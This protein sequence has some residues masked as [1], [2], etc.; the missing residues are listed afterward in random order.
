[1]N[2]PSTPSIIPFSVSRLAAFLSLLCVAGAESCNNSSATQ[3]PEALVASV[4]IPVAASTS[5]SYP[6]LEKYEI[7]NAILNRIA[8]PAGFERIELQAG[9]FG[10][11]LRYLPL[12]PGKP[13]IHLY[14][15]DLKRNQNVHV[16]VVDID[17]GT[18]DIQQC[19]D[20]VMRIRAEYLY[21]KKQFQDL[22]FNFTSGDNIGFT[23]WSEG[24]RTVIKGNKVTWTKSAAKDDG[25]KVFRKYMN[26]ICNYAGTSS[27]SKELKKVARTADIQPG[28]VFIIGGFPGHAVLVVDVCENKKTGE[29]LFMIQQSYMPA[30]EIHILKNYNEPA[31]SPWY[32]AGFSGELETPEW[33]FTDKQLM[34][35]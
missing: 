33:T 34:R 26:T 28:D 19:A 32:R 35:W 31:I 12:K 17:V 7:S 29:R 15:G 10:D 14:N 22:H 24:Y 2:K 13:D 30:Q 4:G 11:W 27:L 23:K 1:M 20:A 21:S 16:A 6:W 18:T 5:N 9:S 3:E 8:V 25:Y